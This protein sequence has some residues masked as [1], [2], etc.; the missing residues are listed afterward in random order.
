MSD[1]EKEIQEVN[2]ASMEK[3]DIECETVTKDELKQVQ[4]TEGLEPKLD[5]YDEAQ[6]YVENVMIQPSCSSVETSVQTPSMNRRKRYLSAPSTDS[7]VK[8][9]KNILNDENTDTTPKTDIQG[10][11]TDLED[12]EGKQSNGQERRRVLKAR[13]DLSLS[14]SDTTV[15]GNMETN[16]VL[17]AVKD[18]QLSIDKRFDEMQVENKAV[19][20]QLQEQIGQV[21]QEFNQRID[22]LTKKVETKVTQGVKKGI[23][24]KF[25]SIKKEMDSELTKIKKQVK[26]NEK[27]IIKVRETL[28]PTITEKL[29]DELDELRNNVCKIQ[30]DLREREQPR[31]QNPS[32]SK[33]RDRNIIIR[34]FP[35]RDNEDIKYI[36]KNLI[37]DSLK[38]RNITVL[39][40]E[41]LENKYNSRP[42]L[43]KATLDSV[44]SKQ[45][46]MKYKNKLK[47]SSRYNNV[48]IEN[49]VPAAQRAI[50]SNFRTLLN[51][52]GESNLQ[53]K[54]SRISV[55]QHGQDQY[56]GIN[57]DE[58]TY[59]QRDNYDNYRT[60]ERRDNHEYDRRE[61]QHDNN[62]TYRSRNQRRE[63]RQNH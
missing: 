31:T 19:I 38:I 41:R 49:D 24:D 50:N 10:G 12:E 55:R 48:Y 35:V 13:R 20:L 40:A 26:D 32:D 16:A 52:L 23:D 7:T 63:E 8:K 36:V 60:Y 44:A 25:K 28:M 5:T 30:T 2:A 47:D 9:R 39:S 34:N 54:G 14:S 6:S 4:V 42:G 22:G 62:G 46:V 37:R 11:E 17:K 29:G 21:R 18:L 53:L 57:R 33:L 61:R 1:S 27:D 43:V 15:P 59:R 3:H 58:S 45:E 51:V 56:A